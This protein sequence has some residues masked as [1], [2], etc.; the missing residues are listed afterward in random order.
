MQPTSKFRTGIK[1]GIVTFLVYFALLFIRYKYFS[2]TPI[3]FGLAAVVSFIVVL[4]LYLFSGIARKK[5][6]NG[7]A[8]FKDIFQ[9]IFVCILI[10]ELAYVTFNFVYLKYVDPAFWDNFKVAARS[11]FEKTLPEDKVEQQM[12]QMDDAGNQ[13]TPVGL[14]RGYGFSVIV[15]SII[16][17]IYASILRKKKEVF[18]ETD[19]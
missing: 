5:E 9:T 7:Y 12:K 16:G 15:D 8:D 19:L 6:L 3:M 17:M 14:L 11:F 1:F 4:V 18:P 10:T 13:I 2:N